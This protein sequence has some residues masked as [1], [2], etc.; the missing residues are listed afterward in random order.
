TPR[1]P[2]GRPVPRLLSSLMKMAGSKGIIARS[3][4]TEVELAAGLDEA[5]V[6]WLFA[7]IRKTIT[8]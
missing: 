7:L 2:D 1:M 8:E 5:E 6:A 4:K 3:D